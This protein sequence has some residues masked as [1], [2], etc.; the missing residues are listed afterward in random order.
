[1]LGCFTRILWHLKKCPCNFFFIPFALFKPWK[2]YFFLCNTFS[3]FSFISYLVQIIKEVMPNSWLKGRQEQR[4]NKHVTLR[5]NTQPTQ[6]ELLNHHSRRRRIADGPNTQQVNNWF[7]KTSAELQMLDVIGR[8]CFHKLFS[9]WWR[10]SW[11]CLRL[12]C[13]QRNKKPLG[14]RDPM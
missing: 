8:L 2:L 9:A 7:T 1:M 3:L 6:V 10:R 11:T 12:A 13:D 4:P 5:G 14:K